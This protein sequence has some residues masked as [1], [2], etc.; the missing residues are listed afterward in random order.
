MKLE[1]KLP[2]RVYSRYESENRQVIN[3]ILCSQ[4]ILLQEVNL[5]SRCIRSLL[6]LQLLGFSW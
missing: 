6:Q 2:K 3:Q 1:I 5:I 4:G